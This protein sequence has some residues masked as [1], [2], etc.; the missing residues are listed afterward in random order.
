MHDDLEW[1][2]VALLPVLHGNEMVDMKSV[3]IDLATVKVVESEKD[4]R[5]IMQGRKKDY[6]ILIKF[7]LCMNE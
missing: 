6:L 5:E 1:R 3:L 7:D 2:H 4:T